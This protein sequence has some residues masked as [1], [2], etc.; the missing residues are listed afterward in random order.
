[1]INQKIFAVA[2]LVAATVSIAAG[3]FVFGI[4][5]G[6]QI[7]RNEGTLKAIGVSVYWESSCTNNVTSINWGLV[8]PGSEHNVHVWIR[9]EGTVPMTLSM[10]MDNWDPSLASMYITVG[11]N[12]EAYVLDLGEALEAIITLS[13]SN[14]ISD[15]TSFSFDITIA[16][17]E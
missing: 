16:G 14:D 11:W 12:R 6:S 4:L 13:V 2:L 10:T 15:I 17:T 5:P 9:N 3:F 7:I 1:M 8:E